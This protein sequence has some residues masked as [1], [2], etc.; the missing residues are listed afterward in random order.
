MVVPYV[1]AGPI[2]LCNYYGRRTSAG[3]GKTPEEIAMKTILS[4]LIA[5]SV[6]AGVVGTASAMD[7]KEFYERVDRN[8]F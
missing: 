3:I 8:H 2:K 4:A 5:L 7:T 6:I 1:T